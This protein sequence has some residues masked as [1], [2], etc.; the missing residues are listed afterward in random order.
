MTPDDITRLAEPYNLIS[1]MIAHHELWAVELADMDSA[2]AKFHKDAAAELRALAAQGKA[3]GV[4]VVQSE[5]DGEQCNRA[6]SALYGVPYRDDAK[7]IGTFV[8]GFTAEE[9]E[10]YN[11]KNFG[12]DR[13]ISA[14][15]I[16]ATPPAH[17]P[18]AGVTDEMV[19]RAESAY[20]EITGDC[21]GLVRRKA[22]RAAL[23]AA[24]APQPKDAER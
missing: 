22:M 18:D 23:A 5:P 6:L 16:L 1:E 11:I 8:P 12:R 3:G 21:M 24:L 7:P 13:L 15:R 14:I 10:A 19:R 2:E 4:S 9:S 20:G 17:S